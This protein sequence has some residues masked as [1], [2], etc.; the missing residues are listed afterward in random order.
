MTAKELRNSIL[1]LAIQ[2]KLVKQNPK[3]KPATVLLEKIKEERKKLIKEKKIKKEKYSK[4][5]KKADKYYEEFEDGTI[6]DIT[7]EIPFDIPESWEWCRFSVINYT[8]GG[9]NNQIKSTEILKEGNFPVISQGQKLID[10]YYN[11]EKKVYKINNPVIMFGDHTKNVKY[12]DFNF[13]IGADGTKFIS[14]INYYEKY[15]YY[16]I[17]YATINMKSRG[18]A[19]HFT[20]LNSMYMP[21]PPI[22]E[23]YR[24]VSEIEKFIPIIEQY[25]SL[26]LQLEALNKSYKENLKKSIL[27]YAIQGKLVKQDLEEE[28]AEVLINKI[29][30][31]KRELIKTKKIKK[32]NLSIIHKNSTDNQFYEKFDDGTVNNITNEIPFDIPNN[33][34]W[35][36][37]G[38]IGQTNIGLTYK[39]TDISSKGTIVLRSSNIKK[40]KIDYNDIIKVSIN[41]PDNKK[42]YKDDILIC[43]RNGSKRLIGKSALIDQNGL[44]FGA[45]MAIY[46]SMYNVYIYLILNSNYF[47][48][49]V[50]GEVGTTTINQLTQPIIKN[51]LIPLPPINEQSKIVQK[52]NQLFKYLETAE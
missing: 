24:I 39:P 18:Y 31:E 1:Q 14:P 17:I 20:I 44:T 11:D 9:K 8:V 47:K 30:E 34:A 37:L 23:Q 45:F 25:N 50:I 4:I 48:N 36:R 40:G 5:Y 28:S 33:W 12:I 51:F 32:D 16:F 38:N 19:R 41:I 21:I 7:E 29:L 6:N 15:L 49:K 13:I 52:T 22:D 26:Y 43:V 10:G 3:D 42:C 2:G 46:R 27:Q 35:T